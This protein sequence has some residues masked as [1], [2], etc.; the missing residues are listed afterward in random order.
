MGTAPAVPD[1]QQEITVLKKA[2][3]VVAA[4]AAGLLAVSPLAFAG[5]S[6]GKSWGHGDVSSF[7]QNSEGLIN[8]SDTNVNA[9]INALNC[10]EVD[11][12][13][14]PVDV[15]DVTAPIAGALA[16]FGESETEQKTYVDNSCST[17]QGA[18]TVGDSASLDD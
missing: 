6:H 17:D 11:L 3:I 1:I 2:G 9:P 10:D 5:E 12:G 14:V 4:A 18:S 7:E 16:L 8:V 13:L 15:K